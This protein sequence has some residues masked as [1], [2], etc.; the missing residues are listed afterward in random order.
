MSFHT[1]WITVQCQCG[2]ASVIIW[3]TCVI[4]LWFLFV[5]SGWFWTIVTCPSSQTLAAP[6]HILYW[7][8]CSRLTISWPWPIA[9]LAYRITISYIYWTNI[10]YPAF[11]TISLSWTMA[12]I[13]QSSSVYTRSAFIPRRSRTRH[14]S[15]ISLKECL[16]LPNENQNQFVQCHIVLYKL[17]I[18]YFYIRNPNCTFPRTKNI[19]LLELT[20][21]KYRKLRIGF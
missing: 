6:P 11:D 18:V 17:K 4:I 12:F 10:S 20:A 3:R 2:R 7:V 9:A 13:G 21:Q 15:R 14:T 19:D 1:D 8:F 16:Y 5:F